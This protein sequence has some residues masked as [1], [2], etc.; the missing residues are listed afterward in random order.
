M[1]FLLDL[2]AWKNLEEGPCL[3]KKYSME[4]WLKIMCMLM[5]ILKHKTETEGE[6]TISVLL[7]NVCNAQEKCLQQYKM[8]TIY[9]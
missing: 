9:N 1:K 7:Q 2:F 5:C 4:M 3:Q 6:E 8:Y